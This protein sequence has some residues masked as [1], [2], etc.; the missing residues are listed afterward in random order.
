[1]AGPEM[2]RLWGSRARVAAHAEDGQAEDEA[3]HR[4][5]TA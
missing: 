5:R 4:D 1:M 2:L 3:V